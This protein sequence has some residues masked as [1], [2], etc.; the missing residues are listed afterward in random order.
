MLEEV[1]MRLCMLC[2]G[3]FEVTKHSIRPD[4][5][6]KRAVYSW[7]GTKVIVDSERMPVFIVD[8]VTHRASWPLSYTYYKGKMEVQTDNGVLTLM[9]IRMEEQKYDELVEHW[10]CLKCGTLYDTKKDAMECPCY[11]K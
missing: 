5:R 9:P 10:R 7:P 4:V 8:G 11:S 6:K 2:D 3:T 1:L